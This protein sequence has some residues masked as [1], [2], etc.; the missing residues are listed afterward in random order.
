MS[1]TES[2]KVVLIVDDDLGFVMWLGQVL[3]Q[4]GMLPFPAKNGEEGLSR[5]RDLHLTPDLAIVNPTVKNGTK[6]IRFLEPRTTVLILD[7]PVPGSRGVMKRFDS[8]EPSAE[9][10]VAKVKRAVAGSNP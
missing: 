10:W 9:K 1:K 5:I 3:S 2:A 8:E 7:V 4:A 6:L